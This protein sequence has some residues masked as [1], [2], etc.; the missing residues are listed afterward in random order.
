MERETLRRLAAMPEPVLRRVLGAPIVSSEGVT[1]DIEAQLLLRALGLVGGRDAS[2]VGHVRARA[3]MDRSAPI[4][5][6]EGIEVR[7]TDRKIPGPGGHIHVRITEPRSWRPRR[8]VLVFFHGGGWVVGSIQSHDGV[9]RA[10]ATKADAIVV[11]VG[12]RLA[13]EHKFPAGLDDALA[14]TRW[15]LAN[16][17]SIGGD[18]LRVAV[19]GDSAGG[20]LAAV[21]ALETRADAVRPVFQLLV[22]PATDLTRQHRS[23]ALFREGFM[24]TKRAVDAYLAAYLN[25]DR[26]QRNPRAS[27][28]FAEDLRGLPPAFVLTAGFDP[29]RDEGIAYAEKMRAAGVDVIDRCVR[30]TIHGFF[31]FG[32][33]FAHAAREVDGA[34]MALREAFAKRDD[35][36]KAG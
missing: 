25:D 35:F 5:D 20:N 13:P 3:Q 8:P 33:V 34:A 16:A 2:E 30:G 23:H 12:Y 29:L 18:P 7:R 36:A 26:E 10:L 31:S 4:V 9:C 19:G 22:Y 15:V 21:V 27:P 1:L 28:L 32:G 6:Y 11:S 14:A 17:G 24:L